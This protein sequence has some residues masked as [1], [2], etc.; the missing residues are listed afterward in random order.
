MG[1]GQSKHECKGPGVGTK[2]GLAEGRLRLWRQK[3][4]WV[5]GGTCRQEPAPPAGCV[6]VGLLSTTFRSPLEGYTWE[7]GYH[8]VSLVYFKMVSSGVSGGGASR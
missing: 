4:S 8:M 1:G 2:W 6:E 5:G 3:G 7:S